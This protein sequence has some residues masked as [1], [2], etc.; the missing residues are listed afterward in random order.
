[1]LHGDI[2]HFVK[3]SKAVHTK[4][5]ALQ[6]ALVVG[7]VGIS[8]LVPLLFSLHG[9]EEMKPFTFR[10][11]GPVEEEN[12]RNYSLITFNGLVPILMILFILALL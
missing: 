9:R 6:K 11:G 7:Y 1:M 5:R 12:Q 10:R 2:F 8:G 3:N 4:R